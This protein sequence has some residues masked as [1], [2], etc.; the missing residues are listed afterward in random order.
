[1]NTACYKQVPTGR[2]SGIKVYRSVQT[3]FGHEVGRDEIDWWINRK[4][5]DI[6][7]FEKEVGVA[8]RAAQALKANAGKLKKLDL[9]QYDKVVS[10][11][12]SFAKDNASHLNVVCDFS[13]WLH[14]KDPLAPCIL[15]TYKVWGTTR[16]ADR[17]AH[18]T[19]TAENPEEE[20]AEALHKF[21]ETAWGFVFRG[22]YRYDRAVWEIGAEIYETLSASDIERNREIVVPA[23]RVVRRAA[24]EITDECTVFFE[25]LRDSLRD[26]QNE[27]NKRRDR[28]KRLTSDSFLRDFIAKAR[29]SLK[30]EPLL[31]DFKETLSFWHAET[32]D[33]RRR[34]K[35]KFVEDVAG[36]ANAEGGCLIVGVTDNRRVVGVSDDPRNIENRLTLTHKALSEHFSYPRGIYR[37]SQILVLDDNGKERLCFVITVAR[38][39]E[40]VGV[41]DGEGSYTYPQ[42]LG[43]GISKG[44]KEKLLIARQHDKSDSYAFL[45]EIEAFVRNETK[46][47]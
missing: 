42:R 33:A 41:C 13:K 9:D 22:S 21:T 2:P 40:P 20:T 44:D 46:T 10:A 45:D 19:A 11:V 5:T 17:A 29:K 14:K 47:A 4:E 39:C 3:P 16:R 43:S 7:S 32:S 28:E 34:Q 35:V 26:I 25:F 23:D 36:F 12:R 1:M 27:L 31:W 15:F 37:L 38:A 18:P 8:L 24:R 30:A 6:A